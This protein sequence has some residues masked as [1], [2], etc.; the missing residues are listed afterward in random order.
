M[1]I[2]KKNKMNKNHQEKDKMRG[3]MLSIIYCFLMMIKTI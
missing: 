3:I 2:E 1:R